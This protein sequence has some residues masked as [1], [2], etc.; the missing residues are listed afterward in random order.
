M[1]EELKIKFC[2]FW[3]GF[4]EGNNYF[5]HLLSQRYD[6][7]LDSED[8][9]LLF[10]SVDYSRRKE[11]DRYKDHR[12]KKIFYTGES[13][14][15][16]F[17]SEKSIEMSNHQ[18]SY[19]IGK[20]DFAFSFDFMADPRQYRLPLWAMQIDWFGKTSYGNPSF[21]LPENKIDQNQYIWTPKTQF[22]A[23]VFNNPVKMRVDFYEK[24]SQ[25]K[26]VHGYG[27]PFGNWFDGEFQKYD[28]LKN[29]R[30]S[31]CFENRSY[32][33]YFTEKPFH[34]K[35][36]GTV[37]IYFSHKTV[38][39]DFNEKAFINLGDFDN[40][41]NLVKY[42]KKV[43]QDHGLYMQ[44]YNQPLFKNGI[45]QQFRP[46]SILDFFERSILC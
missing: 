22:C 7:I 29:Y 46:D 31:A 44:Y 40:M 5:Y 43:D 34:A 17:D 39:K 33:G 28:V 32:A 27:K 10:F 38:S 15:P 24:M 16:N 2:D 14:L 3:D 45:S 1:R 13:V 11:R 18:A 4:D 41:D 37:P 30:F 9:D 21:L 36:A 8:P 19:S 20:C 23:M 25:Y 12:C 42:V 26:L 35:T 6:V